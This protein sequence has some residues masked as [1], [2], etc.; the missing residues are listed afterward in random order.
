MRAESRSHR[1]R[2]I[3]AW[4]EDGPPIAHTPKARVSEG[5]AAVAARDE[6][7]ASAGARIGFRLASAFA[8]SGSDRFAIAFHASGHSAFGRAHRPARCSF[9]TGCSRLRR[10]LRDARR[11]RATVVSADADLTPLCRADASVRR[12]GGPGACASSAAIARG[13]VAAAIA[14]CAIK[15]E[16][17]SWLR[18]NRLAHS[19]ERKRH[20]ARGVDDVL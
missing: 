5:S 4:D 17:D 8:E 16:L 18:V 1:T 19:H 10:R 9:S 15:R 12:P 14:P 6:D 13:L 3:F 11:G 7:H 2:R 20:A